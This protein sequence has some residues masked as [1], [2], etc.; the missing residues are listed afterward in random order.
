MMLNIAVAG[1]GVYVS[2][3]ADH[4]IAIKAPNTH[5]ANKTA[6]INTFIFSQFLKG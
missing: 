1:A 2:G 6:P 3:F 4:K 5:T